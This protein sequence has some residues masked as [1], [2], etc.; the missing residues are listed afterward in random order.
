MLN[1]LDDFEEVLILVVMEEG[2]RQ[3]LAGRVQTGDGVLILVVMEEG[4]RRCRPPREVYALW[5]VS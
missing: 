2:Q 4:Q 5:G 1:I 3:G